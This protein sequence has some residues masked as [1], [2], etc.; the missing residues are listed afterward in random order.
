MYGDLVGLESI[1][2]FVELLPNETLINSLSIDIN[3][4]GYDDEVIVVKKS[5]S[6]NLM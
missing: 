1:Y 4:D 2:T 5:T 3:N 6:P